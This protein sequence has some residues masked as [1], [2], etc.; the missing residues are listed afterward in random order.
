MTRVDSTGPVYA[1]RDQ[2]QVQV[3]VNNLVNI[4]SCQE[5]AAK[6]RFSK[7]RDYGDHVSRVELG[8]NQLFAM[9]EQQAKSNDSNDSNDM[10]WAG[11]G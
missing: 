9:K 4:N 5:A 7:G 2:V 8:C 6:R 10:S 11:L 3:N 1:L